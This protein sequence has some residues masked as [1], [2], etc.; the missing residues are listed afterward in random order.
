MCKLCWLLLF[1]LIIIF[2]LSV[3][4]VYTPL[5]CAQNRQRVW[6]KVAWTEIFIN[7]ILC[8]VYVL[9]MICTLHTKVMW[10]T[11]ECTFYFHRRQCYM[12]LTKHDLLVCFLK[13]DTRISR[14]VLEWLLYWYIPVQQK[15]LMFPKNFPYLTIS[16]SRGLRYFFKKWDLAVDSWH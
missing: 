16:L 6:K 15:F 13:I 12:I 7:W 9:Y 5:R 10:F 11:V 2:L 14:K 4:L 1:T 8:M 3:R